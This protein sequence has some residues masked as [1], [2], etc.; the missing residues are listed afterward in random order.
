MLKRVVLDELHLTV[1]IPADLPEGEAQEIRRTVMANEF[2]KRLRK[3][4]RA[5]VRSHQ[6]LEAVSVSVSR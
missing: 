4:F 3:A 6:G 5:V 1:R 2:M